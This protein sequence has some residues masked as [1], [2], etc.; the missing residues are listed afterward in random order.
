M[1]KADKSTDK[2]HLNSKGPEGKV[3]PEPGEVSGQSK[4]VEGSV[5]ETELSKYRDSVIVSLTETIGVYVVRAG[6]SSFNAIIGILPL[7]ARVDS[8]AEVTIL[9]SVVN[10]QLFRKHDKVRDVNMQPADKSVVIPGFI[11]NPVA[12]QL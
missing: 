6:S 5:T 8:G 9:S 3:P 4:H 7:K 2:V 12:M 11:T 10:K 1:A